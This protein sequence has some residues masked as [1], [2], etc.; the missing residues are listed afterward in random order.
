MF[1]V[2]ILANKKHGTIYTGMTSDLVRRVWQHKQD[3]VAGFTKK[4]RTH[5]LVY[6]EEHSG[7]NEAAARERQIKAWKRDWKIELIETKNADWRDL[8][9]EITG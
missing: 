5:D 2:Y 8:Y 4:Y 1:W 6:F 3:A 9:H 7:P